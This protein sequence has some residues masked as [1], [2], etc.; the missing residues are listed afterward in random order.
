[1]SNPKDTVKTATAE[2]DELFAVGG[3]PSMAGNLLGSYRVLSL[4][5]EG[6]MGMVYRAEHV[7]LGRKVAIK[8]LRRDLMKNKEIVARFFNEARAVNEIGHPN[9]V[10]IIDFVENFEIEPPLVYMVME[11]LSGQDLRGRIEA[12]SPMDPPEV[13]GIALQVANALVA[14]HRV[15]ILHRDLKPD[16]IF[17][18]QPDESLD[19]DDLARRGAQVKLLDFGVARAFGE[20]E[21]LN[22]TDPGTAIGT[23]E[24][25]APEQVLGRQLDHR[26]DIYALGM[27]MYEMLTGQVPFTSHSYG[28]VLIKAVKEQPAPI[29]EVRLE[30]MSMPS[31]LEPL[32]MRCLEKDPAKRYQ[33]ARELRRTLYALAER[34]FADITP[35]V[36]LTD[37][38]GQTAVITRTD[39]ARGRA[40]Y[41]MPVL[42]LLAAALALGGWW[43]MRNNRTQRPAEVAAPAPRAA[44][45]ASA[46]VEPA[47]ARAPVVKAAPAP[48]AADAQAAAAKPGSTK[49]ASGP[50]AKAPAKKRPAARKPAG[51]RGPAPKALPASAKKA[52]DIVH[53][54]MDPFAQ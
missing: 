14:V 16:N 18:V 2:T 42:V 32:V 52:Q 49:A 23:P 4:L 3:G 39:L 6:G 38:G 7:R 19:D 24:Y 35:E 20:R 47:P 30:G 28:E 17:L 34:E 36:H 48:A 51:K 40:A 27:V 50:V 41:L 9:I 10:D 26:T 5:G 53:G 13:V 25:M 37:P 15:K 33:N 1:M 31:G 54:T 21:R 12:A 8:V 22:V 46:P 45:A 43:F 29:S 11:L 44:P